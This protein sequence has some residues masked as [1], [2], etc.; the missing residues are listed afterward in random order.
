ML[1]IEIALAVAAWK[2]GWRWRAL[3]PFAAAYAVAFVVGAA[4]GAG[5]GAFEPALPVFFLIEV[6]LVIALVLLA[7]REPRPILPDVYPETTV[8]PA[9]R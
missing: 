3:L 1:F 2:R 4:V 8:A 6:A 5:G 7:R 9:G